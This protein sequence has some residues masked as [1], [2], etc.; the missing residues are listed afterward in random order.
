MAKKKIAL[1]GG[2]FDPIHIG[3]ITV[4]SYAAEYIGAVKTIFVP[5]KLS[6]LKNFSPKAS[7]TDRMKMASLAISE[8]KKFELSDY[9][10]KKS[11]TNYTLDTVKYFQAQ[12]GGEAAIYCLIGADNLG[13]LTRWY[14][15]NELVDTCNLSLMYRAGYAQPDISR[16]VESLGQERVDKLQKNIIQT[17]L[18][19][20]SSTEIR[21]RL[22]TGEDTTDLLCPL[23]ADYISEH[24]LYQ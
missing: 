11:D 2:T 16:L 17:P 24:N 9:E 1:F 3:H 8:N 20:I 12:F 14:K 18:I 5:V 22:A 7:D 19:N 10:L 13:D 21:K 6:P 23:V 15:I 4:A